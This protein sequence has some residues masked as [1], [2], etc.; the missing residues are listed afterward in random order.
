VFPAPYCVRL[1]PAADLSDDTVLQPDLSVICDPSK[2]DERGC[3]GAPDLIIEI[4]SPSTSSKDK[5]IKFNLYLE[6]GVRE[7]W[8]V[9]PEA[10]LVEVHILDKGRYVT[11]AYGISDPI[12]ERLRGYVSE[13]APLTVLPGL[14][15]D[16]KTIF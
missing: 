15:I 5:L 1:F 16:L 8:V 3:N 9:D 4:L 10:R 14:S 2:I 13:V 7:Y 11:S 12:E 6:A